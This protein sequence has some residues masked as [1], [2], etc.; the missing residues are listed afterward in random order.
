LIAYYTD[1]RTFGGAEAVLGTLL[2]ELDGEFDA[3]VVGVDHTVVRTL[4]SRRPGTQARLLP[5]VA[6]KRDL[7][8]FVANVRGIRR[9]GAQLFQANLPVPSS[10]QYPLA[11][12]TL[13]PGVRTLALEHLP[14]PLDGALQL[15]LKRLTSRRLAAHV[16]VGDAV[17]RRI[18]ALAGL[19]ASSIQTI[20]NGVADVVLEP[21]PRP[22]DGPVIGTIGRLDHQKGLDLLLRAL[23]ELPGAG[24][25]IVGDGPE[26]AELERLAA[27][28][29]VA[30]RVRFEGW[31]ADARRHLTAIDVFVLP[32]R[33]EGFPLAI[34]EA[35]LAA[36]PV[37]ATSV[38]SVAESVADGDTGLLVAPEDPVALAGALRRL[39]ADPGQRARMGAHGRARALE[40]TPAAMARAY[41]DLYRELLQ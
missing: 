29:G 23:A 3:L 28:L 15:R 35:M 16:A 24:L 38:G 9:L 7:G 19:P 12:A 26:R 18:E 25:S 39:L 40:L 32:S 13:A 2:A 37:V 1:A 8:S 17:A 21:V 5:S 10:C 20:H 30:D 14:Y 31:R 27:G 11:A 34:L 33:F 36:L 6:G 41:S 4:A 22:F